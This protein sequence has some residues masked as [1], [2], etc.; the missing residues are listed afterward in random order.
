M[1]TGINRIQEAGWE[2][3]IAGEQQPQAADSL[4]PHAAETMRL[5]QDVRQT[6]AYQDELSAQDR[7]AIKFLAP[8]NTYRSAGGRI[9]ISQFPAEPVAGFS[10][11]QRWMTD[12]GEPR[13][14]TQDAELREG[15]KAVHDSLGTFCELALE[16]Y[17]IEPPVGEEE[18]RLIVALTH[19]APEHSMFPGNFINPH[20]KRTGHKDS[21]ALL[22]GMSVN[23]SKEPKAW[24]IGRSKRDNTRV[25]Q[26]QGDVVW[27]EGRPEVTPNTRPWHAPHNISPEDS[28]AVL[29]FGTNSAA[30]AI[31]EQVRR[32]TQTGSVTA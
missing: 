28:F 19:Y 2:L 29:L 26:A 25:E 17:G 6:D 9:Y 20:T 27:L 24:D 23:L 30:N 1:L 22:T 15:L 31:T 4:L 10:R 14:L 18:E 5:Y 16:A 12:S 3:V 13:V 7:N 32:T 11:I 8:K 21:K